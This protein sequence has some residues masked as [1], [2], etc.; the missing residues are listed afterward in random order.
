MYEITGR[1]VFIR[2][3]KKELQLS[4]LLVTDFA[5]VVP[6]YYRRLKFVCFHPVFIETFVSIGFYP[7]SRSK[8]YLVFTRNRPASILDYSYFTIHQILMI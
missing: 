3:G 6:S 2:F 1:F 4:C 8:Y 5:V 7:S